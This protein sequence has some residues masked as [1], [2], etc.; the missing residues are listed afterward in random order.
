VKLGVAF[1]SIISMEPKNGS[2]W[3]AS[4]A[5]LLRVTGAESGFANIALQEQL[6]FM[7]R[8]ILIASPTARENDYVPR[9]SVYLGNSQLA[10]SRGKSP[11]AQG[12]TEHEENT[13]GRTRAWPHSNLVRLFLLV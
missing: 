5:I 12:N 1:H 8:R 13:A 3:L 7:H 2:A 6:P 4:D 9:S 11:L 10:L